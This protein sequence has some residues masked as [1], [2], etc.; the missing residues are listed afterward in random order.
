MRNLIITRK[1][2]FV[3]SLGKVTIC[4]EDVNGNFTIDKVLCTKLGTVKN[5]QTAT[6]QIGDHATRVYAIYD[7][8]SKNYCYDMYEVAAGTEDVHLSGKSVYNPMSGNPFRFDNN[9]TPQNAQIRKKNARKGTIIL[10]AAVAIGVVIGLLP[11]LM[12]K[13]STEPKTF[14]DQGMSITLTESFRPADY[15]GY[16]VSYESTNAIM[17]ALREDFTDMEGFGELTLEEYGQLVIDSNE[18]KTPLNTQNG[19]VSCSYSQTVDGDSFQY[20]VYFFK[21]DDAFWMVQFATELADGPLYQPQ[22]NEWAQ[23][24]RFS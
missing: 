4:V 11:S 6:F 2:S 7:E 22:I 5:G 20:F 19:L 9:N 16:D 1:K 23:S 14:T 15:D 3:A 17:F 21:T 13:E 8:L 24:I 18:L 10:V 12:R